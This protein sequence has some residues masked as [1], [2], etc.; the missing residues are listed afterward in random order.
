MSVERTFIS[1]TVQRAADLIKQ[2]KRRVIYAAPG[3]SDDVGT[4]LVQAH[5]QL[6][7][8]A[9]AVLLDVSE[10]VFRLG[11]GVVEAVADLRSKGVT[12]RDAEGLRIAFLVAD[13]EG[14]IFT[15][16]PLLVEA[17]KQVDAFP[18]A[19]RAS[20][21]QI[22]R[23]VEAV[24]PPPA[25]R[26]LLPDPPPK[27]PSLIPGKPAAPPPVPPA[28]GRAEIGQSVAPPAKIEAVA[29]T[30]RENPPENFD[31]SR[32]VQV[33]SAHIQF[34]EFEV[35][36]AQIQNQTV[37]LPTTLLSSIRD[38]STRNRISAAFK[39]VKPD[40]KVAGTEIK[41]K[42]AEIRKTFIRP[43]PQYGGVILKSNRAALEAEID[44]LETLIEK[45]KEVVTQRF[46]T[47]A[48]KS[49]EELVKA[50][51]RDIARDPPKDLRYQIKGEKPT[52]EEAKDYLRD[53]L[54]KAFPKAEDINAGMKITKVVKDVTWTTLNSGDFI[55]W[56][57]KQFPHRKDLK[58]PFD[59][60]RAAKE[61]TARK[62]TVTAPK[63]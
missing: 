1:L 45:H 6:G 2:A 52:T 43:H 24:L 23:M 4:A 12:I 58:E 61:A 14:Y 51:W 28:L 27:Q 35:R 19:V 59:L 54:T 5:Q 31:L 48:R 9:V 46:E 17:P 20:P 38:E 32:V 10:T 11:Y 40:S 22:T 21:D 60:Y 57:T 62:V 15:Q 44:V 33:F 8:D 41:D 42:A 25:Q 7:P 53:V 63:R 39:L 36:G 16:P 49:I 55:E 47:D 56:L 37:S 34:I 13:D 50:F 18:N 30:I 26:S 3:L 29:K